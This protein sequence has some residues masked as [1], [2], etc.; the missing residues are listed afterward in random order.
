MSNSALKKAHR[1]E[2]PCCPLHS[3]ALESHKCAFLLSGK[4]T[5]LTASSGKPNQT[6]WATCAEIPAR[7]SSAA[8]HQHPEVG[9]ASTCWAPNRHS[10]A[11]VLVQWSVMKIMDQN[12]LSFPNVG[13]YVTPRTIPKTGLGVNMCKSVLAAF[14]ALTSRTGKL[15]KRKRKPNV[16][17]FKT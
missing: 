3:F 4:G 12:P 9:L 17:L 8:P 6:T 13:K 14:Q 15:I 11:L 5:I 16:I 1:A 2:K 7:G 10:C